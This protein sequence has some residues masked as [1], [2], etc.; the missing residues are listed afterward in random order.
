[1]SRLFGALANAAA[2]YGEGRF[3][4]KAYDDQQSQIDLE[5]KRRAF[6]FSALQGFQ[7]D[8]MEMQKRLREDALKQR[9]EA[10]IVAAHN[11]GREDAPYEAVGS[12]ANAYL[13]S[14]GMGGPGSAG[15]VRA[16]DSPIETHEVEGQTFG[17]TR[18]G[19]KPRPRQ[20]ETVGGRLMSYDS[21][22]K[23]NDETRKAFEG[24]TKELTMK[25][26]VAQQNQAARDEAAKDR[27]ITV[28]QIR[29]ASRPQPQVP[30]DLF[31]DAE[32]NYNY[33]QRGRAVP[34]GWK[35]AANS[36]NPSQAKS[37]GG[38]GKALRAGL[39]DVTARIY[40][41]GESGGIPEIGLPAAYAITKLTDPD[42][43]PLSKTAARS[44]MASLPEDQQA[45]GN[46]LGQLN[47]VVMPAR[48]GKAI[49]ANEVGIVMGAAQP[50]PG[51]S[52]EMRQQRMRAIF[53][54]VGPLL[55]SEDGDLEGAIQRVIERSR[56]YA[57]R[58][59]SLTPEQQERFNRFRKP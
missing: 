26:D 13:Q 8:Q 41:M 36:M 21:Q 5:N 16:P 28:E 35:P 23:I 12:A 52:P 46:L 53:N 58:A 49:T 59:P 22:R 10:A 1:M 55:A 14:Q 7:R 57:P 40:A 19:A 42:A 17:D 30:E 43:S 50:V 34:R 51:E 56:L 47:S 37:G 20:Y 44:F 48:G 9:D 38:E 31:V 11:S 32:G 33:V 54:V 2:K 18:P 24:Y 29:A 25:R 15:V 39:E 6:E 27:A 4:R 3:K 45:F